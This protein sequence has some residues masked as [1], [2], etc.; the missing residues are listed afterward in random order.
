[1]DTQLVLALVRAMGFR[2]KFRDAREDMR[3]RLAGWGLCCV[4]LGST[5]A[6]AQKGS[7][8]ESKKS[9]WLLLADDQRNQVFQFADQYK[10]YM[11]VA[12]TAEL[13]TREV[14]RL[15]KAAGFVEFTDPSQVKP[16]ARL[17]VNLSL[18]HI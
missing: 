18:I 14:M 12:R 7:V 10:Q 11:S 13:S 15:A 4:M 17:I 6:M 5:L 2:G 9:G 8:W 3:Y 1:M 16:G